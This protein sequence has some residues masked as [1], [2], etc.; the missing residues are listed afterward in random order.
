MPFK[1]DFK[2]SRAR[3]WEAWVD[4]EFA[5]EEFCAF[6]EQTG[7]FQAILILRSSYMYRD[8]EALRQMIW[9]W[10]PSIHTFFFAY[11]EFTVTLED[12]EN[13]WM[14]SP[15]WVIVILLKSSYL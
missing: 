10:C 1:F 4:N 12:I 7:V 13:H 14:L 8:T 6:L 3:S 11:G 9:R 15:S 2:C 5:D